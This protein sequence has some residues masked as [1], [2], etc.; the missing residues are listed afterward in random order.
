[1]TKSELLLSL[2]LALCLLALPA[3][4]SDAVERASEIA[5][6]EQVSEPMPAPIAAVATKIGSCGAE[7]GCDVSNLGSPDGQLLDHDALLAEL[8]AS[9]GS[10]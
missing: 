2:L 9:L 8:A 1:M 6:T 3:F 4:S 10:D 7:F 5:M